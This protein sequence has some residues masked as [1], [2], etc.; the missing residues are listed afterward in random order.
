MKANKQS[1]YQKQ[2]PLIYFCCFNLLKIYPCHGP[3][4]LFYYRFIN[5]HSWRQCLRTC[6]LCIH[7]D[8]HL[9]TLRSCRYAPAQQTYNY[10][11]TQWVISTMTIHI[12]LF[13][14][15]SQLHSTGRIQGHTTSILGMWLSGRAFALHVKGPGF[16]PR[17]LQN[18]LSPTFT[19]NI[20]IRLDASFKLI[21]IIIIVCNIRHISFL[22]YPGTSL[23]ILFNFQSHATTQ[24]TITPILTKPTVNYSDVTATHSI[25]TIH[26]KSTLIHSITK[27]AI[28]FKLSEQ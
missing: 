21:L 18:F 8:T 27:V 20:N 7:V 19:T 4:K 6:V 17:H 22:G 26:I 24:E 12:N 9:R 2:T 5:N 14:S 28:V 10:D 16:D 23:F 25:S 13:P 1:H 11:I 15:Y 3:I